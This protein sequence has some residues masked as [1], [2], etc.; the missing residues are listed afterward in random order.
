[1]ARGGGHAT[2]AAIELLEK[3]V[4]TT[5]RRSGEEE[6]RR[7]EAYLAAIGELG[8]DEEA[9]SRLRRDDPDERTHELLDFQGR[10]LRGRMEE[11]GLSIGEKSRID[12]VELVAIL[13][14]VEEMRATQW[15]H[16]SEALGVPLEWMLEGIRFVP[17]TDPDGPGVYEI[18]PEPDRSG[19][20]VDRGRR[21][22]DDETG[23]AR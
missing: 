4:A 9:A 3:V 14:G 2:P 19:A 12:T 11:L 18:E 8:G 10:K 23:G 6:R 1:M 5:A 20:G 21:P 22:E 15:L 16:V 17:R 7:R 13:F